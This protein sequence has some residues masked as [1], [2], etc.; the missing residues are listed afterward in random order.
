MRVG[1]VKPL[2]ANGT[3]SFFSIEIISF[4]LKIADY[5]QVVKPIFY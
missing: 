4:K 5:D 2:S 3:P 1:T